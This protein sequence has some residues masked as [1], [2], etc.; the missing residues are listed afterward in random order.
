MSEK[1]VQAMQDRDGLIWSD[2]DLIP[3]REARLHMLSHAV[4]HGMGVFEGIRAYDGE[5]GTAVFR[6]QDHTQ[7]L[8]DSAKIL[9][10]RIPF[11]ANVLNQAHVE[12][13]RA[14]GLQECYLRTNVYYDGTTAGVSPLGNGVHVNIAAWQWSAYL[15]GDAST[16]GIRIKTSTYNRLHINSALRKAKANGHYINSALAVQEARLQGF[17]DALLLDTQGYVSECSTSNMFVIRRGHIATP[18]RTTILEGITRD[19]IMVLAGER[20][21]SVQERRITRDEV[22]CADEVFVTGT[23][24]EITPV[25]EVDQRTIGSGEPGPITKMLQAAFFDA[26]CGRDPLHVDWLT[27]VA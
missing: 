15:G 20:G 16:R 26:V 18:D 5:Q 3:W 6:L 23:A 14:N 21:R 10:I 17:N 27:P 12:T 19:T 7:R 25:V 9:Q 4:Q 13:I 8:F 24:A 1:Q 2:G 11:D 22:Y